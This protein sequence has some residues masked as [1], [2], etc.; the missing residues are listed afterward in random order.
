[1]TVDRMAKS[2]WSRNWFIVAAVSGAVITAA[3]TAAGPGTTPGQ[4][5]LAL[6]AEGDTACWGL[7]T[8]A[9]RDTNFRAQ[10]RRCIDSVDAG[11]RYQSAA[12]TSPVFAKMLTMH[13]DVPEYHDEQRL[14][15]GGNGFGP[16][17]FIYAL[18]TLESFTDS[19]QFENHGD[20]GALIGLVNVETY[21]MP[22]VL[23]QTYH[24]LSLTIGVNCVYLTFR[25]SAPPPQRW[26]AYLTPANPDSTCSSSTNPV[27]LPVKRTRVPGNGERPSPFQD[28]PPVARFG[29]TSTD[30]PLLGFKCVD[31]WCDIGHGAQSAR[32]PMQGGPPGR[33]SSIK[34]WHDEQV[35]SERTP[36]AGYRRAFRA[37]LTPRAR[38]DTITLDD[39]SNWTTLATISIGPAGA[40]GK[41]LKWGMAQGDNEVQ[42]KYA[43]PTNAW[44][45]QMVPAGGGPPT[46]LKFVGRHEHYDVPV[47]GTARFRWTIGDEGIW[48]PCGQGCC[49]VEGI[50]GT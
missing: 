1:M 5:D 36:T 6:A 22:G 26:R 37:K 4:P 21:G 2:A 18:P 29:E 12:R 45:A 49:K 43:R 39:L 33:E 44:E 14:S 24:D 9:M 17:A 11:R 48:V 10:S 40:S 8:R 27:W 19:T 30:L 42:L 47:P 13:L 34:G 23:P 28:Y 46:R 32:P 41:Y 7:M 3:C 15:D 38:L 35:V 20:R 25:S 16:M 31:G 50:S